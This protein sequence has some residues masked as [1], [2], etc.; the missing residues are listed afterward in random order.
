MID[1]DELRKLLATMS[2]PSTES[3][4]V[5]SELKKRLY[6]QQRL[7]ILTYEFTY[8]KHFSALERKIQKDGSNG[9]YQV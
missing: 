9:F 8:S 3:K 2:I 4:L 6:L 7:Y 5:F 1:L